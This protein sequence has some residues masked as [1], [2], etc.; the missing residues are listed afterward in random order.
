MRD[1]DWGEWVRSYTA[2]DFWYALGYYSGRKEFTV[3]PPAGAST[4]YEAV[5]QQGLEDGFDARCP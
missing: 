4:K 3:F 5:F 2:G 1:E